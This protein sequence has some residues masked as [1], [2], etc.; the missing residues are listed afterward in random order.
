MLRGTLWHAQGH[1]EKACWIRSESAA[2]IESL[3]HFY[4]RPTSGVLVP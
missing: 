3:S 2:S 1:M 4:T